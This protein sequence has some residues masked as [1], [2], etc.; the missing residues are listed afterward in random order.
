MDLLQQSVAFLLAQQATAPL[1]LIAQLWDAPAATVKN[2][3]PGGVDWPA[4]FAPQQAR[5][6]LVLIAQL[7]SP[8]A[9]SATKLPARG[10]A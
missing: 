1:V 3:P 4:P 8:P 9:L 6:P 2:V 5:A 10:V 7:W